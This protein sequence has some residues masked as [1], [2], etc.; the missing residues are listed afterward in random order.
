MQVLVFYSWVCTDNLPIEQQAVYLVGFVSDVFIKELEFLY[1]SI[2]MS[3]KIGDNI[4]T[5]T[6]DK[7][8]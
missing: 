6:V 8:M 3:L 2:G 5:F 1:S 4:L 7:L